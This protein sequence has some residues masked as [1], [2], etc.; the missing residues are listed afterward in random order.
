MGRFKVKKLEFFL[1]DKNKLNVT[2]KKENGTFKQFAINYS[3]KINGKWHPIYRVDNYH[4]YIHEQRLWLSKKPIP[5]PEYESMNLK[6]VFD[7]F[8]KVIKEG[9]LKFKNYYIQKK[10]RK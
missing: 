5:L 8:Y 1:D 2:I 9:C 7:H 6:E 10:K 4:G 3:A